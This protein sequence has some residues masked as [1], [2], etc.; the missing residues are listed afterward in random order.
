MSEIVDDYK[1]LVVERFKPA[2]P[3]TP[4]EPSP[5]PNPHCT[6]GGKPGCTCDGCF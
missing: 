2:E 3:P 6:S 5:V 4:L 1:A